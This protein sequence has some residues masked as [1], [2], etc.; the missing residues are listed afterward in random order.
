MLYPRVEGSLS[1]ALDDAPSLFRRKSQPRLEPDP[2]AFNSIEYPLFFSLAI[3]GRGGAVALA[4]VALH[5][6]A[7]HLQ[8]ALTVDKQSPIG[9]HIHD[10]K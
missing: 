10:L 2:Q 9:S 3:L 8:F 5:P 7:V 4:E 1:R 6:A